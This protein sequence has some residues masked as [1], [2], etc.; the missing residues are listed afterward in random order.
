M[1]RSSLT[2]GVALVAVG[3]LLLLDQL[4]TLDAL[5]IL[6]RWWPLVVILAAV[7]QVVTRPPNPVG[8]AT[9]GIIGV[10][11]LAWTTGS[12]DGLALLWPALLIALGAWLLVGRRH[13]TG[14][15]GEVVQVLAL[16][17]DRRRVAT[18]DHLG[19]GEIVTLFCEVDLRPRTEPVC[20][21]P[22]LH[23]R[24]VAIFGDITVE[25]VPA[26]APAT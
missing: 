20:E 11:L 9:L 8:G 19:G 7:A 12:A 18:S 1:N 17:D 14:A 3:T 15:E 10:V 13:R 2:F 6:A 16:F 22:V 26:I 21:G 4:G 5:P 23:L 24:V 25:R